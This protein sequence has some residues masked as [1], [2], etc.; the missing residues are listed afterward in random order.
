MVRR[1][2]SLQ[3]FPAKNNLQADIETSVFIKPRKY[4]ACTVCGKKI[5][6]TRPENKNM[7]WHKRTKKCKHALDMK[8]NN[9]KLPNMFANLDAEVSMDSKEMVV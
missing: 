6:T 2:A 8:D 9:H 3:Y 4:T 1:W 5:D 7:K